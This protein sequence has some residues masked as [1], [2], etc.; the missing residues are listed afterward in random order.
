MLTK[1]R[2]MRFEIGLHL[3]YCPR[4]EILKWRMRFKKNMS[5]SM[6]SLWTER[7]NKLHMSFNELC[8]RLRALVKDFKLPTEPH[9]SPYWIGRIKKGLALKVTEICKVSLAMGKHCNEL[10]TCDV[11]DMET[12][13]VLLGIPWQRDVDYTHQDN[14]TLAT[15]MA[16][17][18]DFQAER[19]ETR[20]SYAL[21]MKGVNDVMENAILVPIRI[22]PGPAGIVQTAKLRKLADTRE[23]GEESVMSTQE[24]I[25]KFIEDVDEDDYFMHASWLSVLEYVNVDGGIVTGCF[26]DVKKFLKNGKLEKVVAVIKSCTPNA[27][28]DLT[29]TLKDLSGIIFGTIRYKVLTYDRFGKEITV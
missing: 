28:G 27:L 17:P 24:Y 22:I 7:R 9:P 23:G 25:R 10:V 20:V 18:K 21:V 12:C 13:H 11:V 8:V 19:K 14:K 16:S 2:S 26:G 3:R 29:A 1:P 15:L 4:L 5:Y 6:S